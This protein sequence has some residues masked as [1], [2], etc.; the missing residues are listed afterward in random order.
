MRAALAALLLVAAACRVDDTSFAPTIDAGQVDADVGLRFVLEPDDELAVDEGGNAALRVA[1]SAPPPAPLTV[2]VATEDAELT[3]TP[4][5][6]TFGPDDF[7]VAQTVRVDAASDADTLPGSGSIAIRAEGVPAID[8]PVEIVD[9]DTMRIIVTPDAV[10]IGESGSSAVTVTLSAEP[11][12]DL[13]VTAMSTDPGAATVAPASFTFDATTWQSGHTFG[14][15]GVGDVDTGHEQTSVSFTA[16]DVEPVSVEVDVQDDDVQGIAASPGNL[17]LNEGGAAQTFTVALNQQPSGT[18][19]VAVQVVGAGVT[20]DATQ[21]AFDASTWDD[22]RTVTVTPVH[23]DDLDD[24]TPLVRLTSTT[25]ALMRDVGVTVLDE[26]VQ[27]IVVTAADPFTITEGQTRTFTAELRHQPSGTVSVSVATTDLG[28]ATVDTATLTFDATTW[29]TEQTVTVQAV[30]DVDLADEEPVVRLTSQAASLVELPVEIA[31]DDEQTLV[32]SADAVSVPEGLTA[33]FTVELG[34]Q[35]ASNVTVDVT[36]PS[37]SVVVSGNPSMTFTPATFSTEQ[38]VTLSAPSDSNTIGEIVSITVASSAVATASTVTA[39]V[40]D[41]TQIVLI[42]WPDDFVGSSA[43]VGGSSARAYRVT[44]DDDPVMLDKLAML[45]DAA[46]GSFKM[47]LYGDNGA[48]TAPGSRL[49]GFDTAKSIAAGYNEFDL[50]T[51]LELAVGT[52]WLVIRVD[53]SASIGISP[54]TNHSLCSRS[55]AF[56]TAWPA[57][58]GSSTCS[59]TQALNIYMVTYR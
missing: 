41:A 15:A 10:A 30:D 38:T 2:E 5:R 40:V 20:V 43:T 47:A 58:F 29:S 23:D 48:N 42:G 26:D 44:V 49:V 36:S 56:T 54:T 18:I 45:A 33:T 35:P 12:G 59:T 8:L 50:A 52:Y 1:L 16:T 51:D 14:I 7:D 17:T 13:V 22:P 9:D 34:Y 53:P 21:L 32:V 57:S 24:E 55:I 4:E 25:P 39:T 46:G 19:T 6:L 27:A 3:V 37:S 31:D 28:A 11:T